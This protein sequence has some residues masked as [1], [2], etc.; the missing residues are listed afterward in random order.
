MNECRLEVYS[1]SKLL[2]LWFTF[3][4]AQLLEEAKI[5]VTVDAV[6]PGWVP[7]SNLG[8]GNGIS[9]IQTFLMQKL[10]PLMPGTVSMKAA[11]DR[12]VQVSAAIRPR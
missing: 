3:K 5:P 1:L 2:N 9:G 7:S 8:H 6:T 10:L 11:A 4:L 12:F